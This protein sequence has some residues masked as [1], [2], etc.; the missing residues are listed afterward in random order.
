[1]FRLSSNSFFSPPKYLL[2]YSFMR[3]CLQLLHNP[4]ITLDLFSTKSSWIQPVNAGMEFGSGF[5][6][7]SDFAWS[8]TCAFTPVAT[9][10][11]G[12]TR[13][14]HQIQLIQLVYNWFSTSQTLFP[15]IYLINIPIG[16]FSYTSYLTRSL[17]T[18]LCWMSLLDP[19]NTSFIGRDAWQ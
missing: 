19:C 14:S 17:E 11:S 13:I 7:C 6:I 2:M 8:Q 5:S 4:T 16:L 3:S 1:M 10:L 12:L 9:I 18:C 15:I